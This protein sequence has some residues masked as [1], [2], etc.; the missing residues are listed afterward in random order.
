MT[1]QIANGGYEIKPRIIF[2]KEKNNLKKYLDFKS[3]NS[4]DSLSKDVFDSNFNLK[5]LFK[6]PE[7]INFVKDAMFASSNE[8]GGTSYRSR[9]TDDRYTFAGKTG[10][11]QIKRFTD[12]QREAEIKQEDIEYKSRDHALFI[13][14]APYKDPQYAISVVVEH[15]GSGSSSAAPVA[16]K[17]IKKVLER[18]ELR[19]AVSAEAGTV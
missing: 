11:S 13:A 18:H 12:A 1:A 17:I 10:S 4:N 16:K 19:K 2:D 7:H 9:L 14:F 5:P 8:P 15:G 3:H 6:N